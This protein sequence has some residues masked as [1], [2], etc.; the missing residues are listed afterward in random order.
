MSRRAVY[1]GTFDPVHVG[2][3]RSAWEVTEWLDAP[4][5]MIP[6]HQPVHRQA[7]GVDA[8]HRLAMLELALRGQ[9]R[10]LADDRE[11]RRGG[12]S[13]MIDTLDSVAADHPGDTLFLVVGADAFAGLDGWHRWQAL[14][15]RAHL[16]VMTRPGHEPRPSAGLSRFVEG[17][18]IA[19]LDGLG[20]RKAGAVLLLPVTPL[21]ISASRVRERLGAGSPRFLVPGAVLEYIESRG[22]YRGPKV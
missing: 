15:E 2:H 3:L 4:V 18:W 21:E 16:V 1:G 8:R 22:L 14:F 10:L 17:R 11:I 9:D 12:P 5:H 19:N 20:E 13:Y 7:P 6:A